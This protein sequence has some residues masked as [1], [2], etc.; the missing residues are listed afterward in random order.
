MALNMSDSEM[1]EKD[2]NARENWLSKRYRTCYITK[3]FQ[4]PR[5]VLR[6]ECMQTGT[7]DYQEI[8][9]YY[10]TAFLCRLYKENEINMRFFSVAKAAPLRFKLHNNKQNT[11]LW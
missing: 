5:C 2:D 3:N 8:A 1:C 6:T 7:C 4:L 10:K 9:R 11:W